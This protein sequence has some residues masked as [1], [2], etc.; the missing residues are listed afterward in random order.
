[1]MR[2]V[3]FLAWL[4]TLSAAA[5]SFWGS[6]GLNSGRVVSIEPLRGVLHF[7]DGRAPEVEFEWGRWSGQRGIAVLCIDW[8]HSFEYARARDAGHVLRFRLLGIDAIGRPSDACLDETGDFSEW[9]IWRG[10]AQGSGVKELVHVSPMFGGKVVLQAELVPDVPNAK[11]PPN[12]VELAVFLCGE[13]D[14]DWLES[15]ELGLYVAIIISG[16]IMLG[17]TVLYLCRR[18]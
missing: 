9:R 3:P 5:L 15:N 8:N 2:R 7:A 10:G 14:E 11:P 4:F 16:S 17:S 13:N 1:M 12:R 18:A 6:S